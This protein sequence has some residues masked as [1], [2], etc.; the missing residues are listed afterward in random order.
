MTPVESAKKAVDD[1]KIGASAS[2]FKTSTRAASRRRSEQKGHVAPRLPQT[3]GEEVGPGS[4]WL[5]GV[6]EEEAVSEMPVGVTESRHGWREKRGPDG[7][8]RKPEITAPGRVF[9]ESPH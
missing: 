7:E 4:Q 8:V 5:G 6:G 1:V 3:A 9:V 2:F